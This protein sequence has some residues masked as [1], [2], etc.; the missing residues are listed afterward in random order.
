MASKTDECC[1]TNEE[2]CI[3]TEELCIQND[4][5]CRPQ[6]TDEAGVRTLRQH[7]IPEYFPIGH[8]PYLMFVMCHPQMLAL[9]RLCFSCDSRDLFF[10]QV[11]LN[12]K[13]PGH[14][15]G[16]WH[17]HW[18]GGGTGGPNLASSPQ[19]YM[20]ENVQNLN[21]TYPRGVAA[22][23]GAIN[24]IPGSHLFRD[25]D[26][27]RGSAPVLSGI[28]SDGIQGWLDGK[29]HPI[30]GE[31]LTTLNVPLPPG[32]MVCINSHGAHAVS[33]TAAHH[34]EPRLAMSFFYF[35]RS[36]RTGHVQPTAWIPPLWGL[37][38]VNGEL[39]PLVRKT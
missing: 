4:A 17:S 20:R 21:L 27:C 18:T 9:Q 39:P 31:A 28:S 33:P 5:F 15:G 12:S 8:V 34:T 36:A 19:E 10:G 3:K 35:R 37:K 6:R 25:P 23:S 2:F 14:A 16:G 1:I 29:I 11:N 38:A 26:S 22:D 24:V 13:L 30:T 32:S 7:V